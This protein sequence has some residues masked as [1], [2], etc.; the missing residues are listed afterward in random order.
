M[1]RLT[2]EHLPHGD[3]DQARVIG[4]ASIC[5]QAHHPHGSPIGDFHGWFQAEGTH[6]IN[7]FVNNYPRDAEP[8]TLIAALLEAAKVGAR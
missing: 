8:W 5:N 7:G 6:E 1:Y 4:T 3:A 2:L